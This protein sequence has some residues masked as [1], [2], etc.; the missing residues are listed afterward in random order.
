M[1]PILLPFLALH[2]KPAWR[3]SSGQR[4]EASSQGKKAW[5]LTSPPHSKRAAEIIVCSEGFRGPLPCQP[6]L[7]SLLSLS[8]LCGLHQSDKALCLWRQALTRI[9]IELA[10]VS[11]AVPFS[12]N[13]GL[14][15]RFSPNTLRS[16][17]SADSLTLLDFIVT[18]SD[19]SDFRA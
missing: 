4:A 17:Q 3:C 15:A 13:Q 11:G 2:R 6:R 8:D 19:W 7:A 18:P 1:A 5:L 12:A 16:T 9:R 14:Q 10:T